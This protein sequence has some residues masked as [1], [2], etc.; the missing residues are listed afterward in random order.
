MDH[1]ESDYQEPELDLDESSRQ[2]REHTTGLL[3][4]II[5]YFIG[6][7]ALIALVVFLTLRPH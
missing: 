3:R 2:D 7:F 1:E 6:M 4:F 5:V